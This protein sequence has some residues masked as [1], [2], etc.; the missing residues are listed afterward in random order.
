VKISILYFEGCPNYPPVVE[1]ARQAV[2][3]HG[4]DAEIEEVE[5]APDD[6]ARH[7]FLG[8]PTVQVDGV[9]IDPAA[10]DRTDFAMSC[11]VYGTRDGLPPREMLLGAL[12]C[13]APTRAPNGAQGGQVAI[14]GSVVSAALSSAC[15]WL[16]LLL[17]AFGTSAAGVSGVLERWRPAFIAAAI[18]S[19]AVGFYLSYARGPSC[20]TG[21]CEARQSRRRWLQRSLLWVST[22][23]V[24]AFIFFPKY[25]GL[26]LGPDTTRTTAS[27]VA[28]HEFI[29]EIDGMTCDACAVTL[30]RELAK[31]E[32]V[33]DARVDYGSRA[34]QVAATTDGIE[35]QVQGVASK[36]GYTAARSKR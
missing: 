28:T 15:C 1:M 13:S 33:V 31:I 24:V 17:L 12:G 25:V 27:A 10:R 26:L 22:V 29:F 5:V 4:L 9:D 14:A 18:V 23:V 21:C 35:R 3:M 7:R 2:A 19:L 6:V 8:S 36:L 30:Q 32:G 34:A 16:P 11:R 20:G